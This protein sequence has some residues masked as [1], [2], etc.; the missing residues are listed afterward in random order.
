MQQGTVYGLLG[1]NGAGKTTAVR[2]LATLLRAGRRPGPRASAATW[3]SQAAAVRRLIGL[4]GQYAALDEY[5]TGRS[6]LIMIGQ[7]AG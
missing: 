7:L 2:V 1:P 3:S 4:T 5:L 6:N